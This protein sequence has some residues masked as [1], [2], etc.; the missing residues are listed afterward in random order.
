MTGLEAGLLVVVILAL[1]GIVGLL[2]LYNRERRRR[3]S[4]EREVEEARKAVAQPKTET[5]ELEQSIREARER[6]RQFRQALSP[7]AIIDVTEL[8]TRLKEARL[9]AEL[10]RLL[11][12]E[13]KLAKKSIEEIEKLETE[14][15]GKT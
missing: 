15:T 3:I 6:I 7:L 13:E 5:E 12:E 2:L 9:Q 11:E 8:T 1:G 10:R 4:A 14:E